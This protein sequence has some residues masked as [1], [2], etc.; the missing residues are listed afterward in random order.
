[1]DQQI[2]EKR[3][4][5]LI[6]FGTVWCPRIQT[7]K[8]TFDAAVAMTQNKKISVLWAVPKYREYLPDEAVIKKSEHEFL[9]NPHFM[10]SHWMPQAA[11]LSHPSVKT[12]I[13]HV[14]PSPVP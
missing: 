11:L 8:A 1:M 9:Q 13:R 6:S 7:L 2:A 4:V 10:F 14:M 3:S 5:V 12:F